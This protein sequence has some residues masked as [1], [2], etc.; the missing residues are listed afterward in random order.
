M[1]G[2]A[3]HY[4]YIFH[5]LLIPT[6]REYT[7]LCKIIP[8]KLREFLQMFPKMTDW[9]EEAGLSSLAGLRREN[10]NLQEYFY[11]TPQR[12]TY[13]GPLLT[14][15]NLVCRNGNE[16]TQITKLGPF[17]IV[18]K[19]CKTFPSHLQFVAVFR[20]HQS[21]RQRGADI[22]PEDCEHGLRRPLLHR[23]AAQVDGIRAV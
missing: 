7:E 22:H 19:S 21:A 1:R 11:T 10:S 23:D 18:K 15:C 13:L 9:Q 17:V 14:V 6:C 20:G 4:S 3:L 5:G 12:C 2:F 16:W 8:A